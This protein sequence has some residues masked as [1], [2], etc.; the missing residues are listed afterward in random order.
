MSE[1]GGKLNV[2]S[3]EKIIDKSIDQGPSDE[4]ASL[5]N[6][7]SSCA[8][9]CLLTLRSGNIELSRVELNSLASLCYDTR[10]Y[11]WTNHSKTLKSHSSTLSRDYDSYKSSG[12]LQHDQLQKRKL[13]SYS[14]DVVEPAVVFY[15]GCKVQVLKDG[16]EGVVVCE[17][18]GG[19]R[20]V[21]FANDSTARFRPSELRRLPSLYSSNSNTDP[22]YRNNVN[23][24]K[25]ISYMNNMSYA[26]MH[27]KPRINMSVIDNSTFN[28]PSPI[29]IAGHGLSSVSSNVFDS[30]ERSNSPAYLTFATASPLKNGSKV[31]IVRDGRQ[32]I[33][34]CE[35][36]GGWRV[37][38]FPDQSTARFRPSELRLF[39]S[40]DE[41]AGGY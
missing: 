6:T 19:W 23:R 34:V 36:L 13:D 29:S 22:S 21:L 16:R 40:S 33:V 7:L 30:D 35:K 5:Q 26:N 4:K 3:D 39:T 18:A 11:L 12:F 28:K 38:Q 10:E 31:Q 17:K 41:Y 37:I 14:S 24:L 25:S 9:E 8:I 2:D 20:E 1:K 32:G 27:K 15:I